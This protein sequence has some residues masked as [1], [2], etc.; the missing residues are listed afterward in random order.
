MPV[1]KPTTFSEFPDWLRWAPFIG[2]APALT[3]R[4]WDILGLVALVSIFGQY[5]LALLQLALRQIQ[6]SLAIPT[7]QLSNWGAVIR[8]GALPAF[9]L[10]LA[11]DKVGRRRLLLVATVAFSLLTGATAFST[12]IAIFVALQ[13]LARTFVTAASLLAGVMIIEEF[14]EHARGWGIGALTAL[15]SCGGGMAAI[16]FALVNVAPFGWRALFI[17]GLVT[18]LATDRLR[19]YLPET[20][21]FQAQQTQQ[22]KFNLAKPTTQPLLSLVHA[23]PGRF[24][25]IGALIFLV[26]IGESAALFYDATYLQQAHGWQPWHVA[27]LNLCAGFMAVLGSAYAGQLSDRWGRKKTTQ[28][29][30]VVL[31]LFV[32]GYFNSRGWLLPLLWAGMLFTSLGAGVA[33]STIRA[34]L[35]PTSYRSTAAGATAVLATLGGALSLVLHGQLVG[36]LGSPWLAVSLLVLLVLLAPLLVQ[37]LPETSGRT[38][39]EIAPE[40]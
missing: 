39:E 19:K 7:G 25:A 17:V 24:M 23:Y 28:L 2:H 18:L 32:V 20:G 35:F 30:L 8:L 29:F 3:R 15:A 27:L 31:P 6:T 38:L 21:R 22:T 13:F 34:E 16:L 33:L 12:T 5:D 40:R 10:T 36:I 1:D 4:Q 9:A 11:A 26:N 14:P 37:I